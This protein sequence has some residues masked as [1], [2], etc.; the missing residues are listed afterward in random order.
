MYDGYWPVHYN[1]SF[2]LFFYDNIHNG[3]LCYYRNYFQLH[4]K[5]FKSI[6]SYSV[7]RLWSKLVMGL[8]SSSLMSLMRSEYLA[9][10]SSRRLSLRCP[11][12]SWWWG[13]RW[14][15]RRSLLISFLVWRLHVC[16]FCWWTGILLLVRPICFYCAVCNRLM[17]P[18]PL[19]CPCFP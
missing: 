7:D 3:C 6:I 16:S 12:S 10:G 19:K 8:L 13:V 11:C 15:R 14:C 2:E 5:H 9:V 4:S 18:L 17:S 1:T